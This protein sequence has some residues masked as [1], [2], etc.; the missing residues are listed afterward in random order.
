M[1]VTQFCLDVSN[2]SGIHLN[3][4]TLEL[5]V[6]L[7]SKSLR[8]DDVL[9]TFAVLSTQFNNVNVKMLNRREYKKH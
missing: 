8:V 2:D 5:I 3:S 6:Y 4:R 9:P 1:F 7:L